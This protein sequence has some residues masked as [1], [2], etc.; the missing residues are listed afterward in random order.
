[1]HTKHS[2]YLALNDSPFPGTCEILPFYTEQDAQRERK[3][4]N[5]ILLTSPAAKADKN[6]HLWVILNAEQAQADY[7]DALKICN[8]MP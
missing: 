6:L 7:P 4:R 3:K 2:F 8:N 1:M 5:N